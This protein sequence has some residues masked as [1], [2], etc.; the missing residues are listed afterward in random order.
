MAYVYL[1]WHRYASTQDTSGGM[2]TIDT[3]NS[4]QA[5]PDAAGFYDKYNRGV[6]SYTSIQWFILEDTT[7][8]PEFEG[9]RKN[10]TSFI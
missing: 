7:T 10:F 2:V 5:S 1:D 9:I 3:E 8:Y 4:H 6:Q